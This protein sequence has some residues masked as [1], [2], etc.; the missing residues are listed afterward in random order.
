M[1]KE[2]LVFI[3][4]SIIESNSESDQIAAAKNLSLFYKRAVTV[5]ENLS[6]SNETVVN[7]GIALS[8]FDAGSCVDDYLRTVL[9]IK[10]IY[11]ALTKLYTDFPEKSINILYAG[12]GPYATLLLPLLPL[13][14][15][16]RINAI[17]LDINE[18][19]LDS[20]HN[21]IS[22]IGLEE[23]K[24]QLTEADAT[25]YRKP[26]NFSIDLA[27]SET[28]HYALTREPQVAIMKNIIAQMPAHAI[29][30]PQE[31]NIDLAYTFFAKEPFINDV[32]N[33]VKDHNELQPYTYSIHLGRLFTI[34]KEH[35]NVQLKNSSKF[36]SNF[37]NLPD[38]F[39]NH[40]DLCIFTEL[41]IF[42]DIELKTAA[43]Y[44][45]NPYCVTSLYNL[46][47]YAAIQLVYDISEIPQW[48]YKLKETIN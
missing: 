16:N 12:C 28:M 22:I 10:G 29:L 27:L 19:S 9:F 21:L 6:K 20:V 40:P 39:S 37:Y 14:D 31:I 45:T 36:E 13:F 42:D 2:E 24:L 43:S 44:I 3:V 15:N 18:T 41:V 38:D 33:K 17:L 48:T 35:L 23:Y 32:L 11:K 25:T 1:Y 47:D 34:S 4:R 8:S 26:E 30:I 46:T 7:G 5:Q